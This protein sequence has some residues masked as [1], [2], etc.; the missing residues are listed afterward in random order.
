MR[1]KKTIIEENIPDAN[2]SNSA[3]PGVDPE[4]MENVTW[5][6]EE[7]ELLTKIKS[8][9]A[10]NAAIKIKVYKMISGKSNPVFVFASEEN[11][12][13][14]QLQ[15]S[16]GGGKYALRF[17]VDGILKHTHYVEVAD[18]P[19]KLNGNGNGNGAGDAHV[20]QVNMLSQQLQWSQ[21]LLLTLLAKPGPIQQ[22]PTPMS[23]LAQGWA[24]IN[25]GGG[26]SK[27]LS[28]ESMITLFTKGLEIGAGKSGDMDWKTAAIQTLKEV[29]PAITSV[30]AQVKGVPVVPA[31]VIANQAPVAVVPDQMLKDGLGF[32]KPKIIGGMP[33]GLA[34]DWVISNAA[35]YQQFIAIAMSKSFEDIV[36]ID[37]DLANE[38]FNTWV[39]Q[40]LD[41]L[42]EH[43]NQS[44][45]ID[46]EITE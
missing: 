38:P 27:G 40:F 39:R 46:A 16:Y 44:A 32:L 20:M 25:G 29:V 10:G 7:D 1:K 18:K 8:Q 43:F 31:S 26:S 37:P 30:V 14:E 3:I 33:V 4:S 36:K 28:A 24:M 12:D 9:F 19:V 21:Q 35:D 13:E 22:P 6:S 5:D 45:T 34:L 11:V 2:G 15:E 41:G 23:E 17:F 42:K